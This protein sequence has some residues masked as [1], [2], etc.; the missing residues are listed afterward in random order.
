MR[1]LWRD[2]TG[3]CRSRPNRKAISWTYSGLG[4]VVHKRQDEGDYWFVTWKRHGINNSKLSSMGI[5]EARTEALIYCLSQLAGD[6]SKI[7]AAVLA[8]E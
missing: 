2:T 4:L 6:Y 3:Y 7:R 8:E 1:D 5:N